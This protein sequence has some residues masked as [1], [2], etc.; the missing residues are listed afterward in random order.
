M[1]NREWR[2]VADYV[3]RYEVSSLGEVRS[4]SRFGPAGFLATL[5][6]YTRGRGKRRHI[7]LRNDNGQATFVVSELVLHAF[8]GPRPA[9]TRAA[10]LDGDLSNSC[11]ENLRWAT[12]AEIAGARPRCPPLRD[13][14]VDWSAPFWRLVHPEALSGCWLWHG[15]VDEANGNYGRVAGGSAHR[16]SWALVNGPIPAGMCV[17]HRCDVRL[18]VNPGHLFL[19]THADN[20]ADKVAKGRQAKGATHSS[21]TS[22][23][24]LARGDR[25]GSRRHPE[26]LPR[27]EANASA[28][29]TEAKVLAIR[30]DLALGTSQR[31]IA[32]TY[33]VCDGTIRSIA[34]G[35]T[36]KFAE[37][38]A[39]RLAEGATP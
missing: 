16:K 18:C 19:G 24:T 20:Q 13:R 32:R 21:R 2:P 23:G 34:R 35:R 17:C 29:L 15:C 36:W 25:N 12:P 27:G 33:G 5:P 10:H 8:A 39:R 14:A 7:A 22:P 9:G 31:S 3:G 38:Y 37:A 28:K 4:L 1:S 11:A 30:S 6:G 26:R